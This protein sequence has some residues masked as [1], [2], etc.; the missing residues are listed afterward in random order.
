MGSSDESIRHSVSKLSSFH[1]VT[2]NQ[3]KKRLVQLG[4]NKKN[5]FVIG[6]PGIENIKRTKILK[7]KDL[8]KKFNFKFL[9][10]NIIVNFYPVTNEK[11]KDDNN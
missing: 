11:N 8:E 7:K 9:K 6:S 2:H 10:K 1:F 5:I 4:E 3:H